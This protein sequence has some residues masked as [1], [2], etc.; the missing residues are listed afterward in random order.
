MDV[1]TKANI[2]VTGHDKELKLWRLPGLEQIE[3]EGPA[4]NNA[5]GGRNSS[6]L[7]A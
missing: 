5:S 1:A 4:T 6:N 2:M 3:W 7:S